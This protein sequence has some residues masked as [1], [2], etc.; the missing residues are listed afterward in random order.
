VNDRPVTNAEEIQQIVE[1]NGVGSNLQI[2]VLR[3]GQTQSFT[4]KL[5]TLPEPTYNKE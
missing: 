5:A 4:A 2:Q 1:K 3:N